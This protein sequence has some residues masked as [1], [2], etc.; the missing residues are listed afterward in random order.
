MADSKDHT[1]VSTTNLIKPTMDAL[2][3]DGQPPFEDIIR[4]DEDEVLRWL[5]ERRDKEDEEVCQ[6][7]A[8]WCEKAKEKYISYFIV[9]PHQKIIRQGEIDMS[10][11]LPSPHTPT[12]CI[13]NQYFKAFI[14]QQEDQLKQYIDES[15]KGWAR[16]YEKSTVP[17]FPSHDSNTEPL[18][19]SHRLQM[20]HTWPSHHMVCR[21]TRLCHH[22]SLCCQAHD[23]L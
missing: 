18:A 1:N 12:I 6:H 15:V 4:H 7:L 23:R 13:P 11:L 10:S 14:E 17:S 2:L 20:G 3:A 19:P 5:A 16:S 8:E 21:C 22:H 9:D